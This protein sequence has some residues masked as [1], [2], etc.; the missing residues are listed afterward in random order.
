M[1]GGRG[2]G[3][4]GGGRGG[5]WNLNNMM[6]S[7]QQISSSSSSSSSSSNLASDSL[8][9]S[10]SHPSWYDSWSQLLLPG[11]V[12]TGDEEEYSNPKIEENREHVHY[13]VVSNMSW[14]ETDDQNQKQL[15]FK[16][17]MNSP[18][19]P[20]STNILDFSS[21]NS[22]TSD[23]RREPLQKS[24]SSETA[25]T[26][27][28][29]LKKAKVSQSSSFPP[30]TTLKVRKEKV[31]DRISILHQLVSPFGKTDT[32]SVLLETIGYIR[33]LHRQVEALSC[34]YLSTIQ[35]QQA[36]F[37]ESVR[38][39]FLQLLNEGDCP[40]ETG[41]IDENKEYC[42]EDGRVVKKDLRSRGLCVV[43]VSYTM[44]VLR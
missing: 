21:I 42:S 33:F 6:P 1:I 26:G 27:T 41:R 36:D 2:D 32:A 34:P 20:N 9:S 7:T 19:R 17:P 18:I 5:W 8:P 44:H 3:G 39:Q 14:E 30:Q 29:A 16:A 10:S 31:G 12:Y 22:I 11:A 37:H 15:I 38:G 24:T 13:P 40:M 35:L 43:P 28:L 25:A 4:G 23:Q